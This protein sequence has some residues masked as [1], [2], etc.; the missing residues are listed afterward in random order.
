MQTIFWMSSSAFVRS[1]LC[2]S[3]CFSTIRS[4]KPGALFAQA[5]GFKT[6][7]HSLFLSCAQDIA[8]LCLDADKRTPSILNLV[9]GLSDS[10]LRG[11]LR[12]R[13]AIWKLPSVEEETDPEIIEALRRIEQHKQSERRAQFDKHYEELQTSWASLQ[14]SE[15]LKGFSTVHDKVSAHTEIRFV[16]DKYQLMDIATLG[17]KWADLRS[18]IDAMQYLVELIGLIVRNAGFAWDMLERQ[19]SEAAIGFWSTNHETQ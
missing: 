17:I 12:E 5:R 2:F 16:A 14:N 10:L 15:P 3:R 9:S 8:K 18:T 4:F 1:T 7:R 19:L 13:Y 6:L 11:E